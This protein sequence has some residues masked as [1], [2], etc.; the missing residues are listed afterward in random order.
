MRYELIKTKCCNNSLHPSHTG[1][2]FTTAGD[3]VQA[4]GNWFRSL[5]KAYKVMERYTREMSCGCKA[6]IKAL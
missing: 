2:L 3:S 6:E 5:N 4:Y 1:H